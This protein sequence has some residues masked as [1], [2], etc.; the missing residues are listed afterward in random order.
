MA[1]AIKSFVMF[2]LGGAG[3]LL[4]PIL[5]AFILEAVSTLSWSHLLNYHLGTLGVIVILIV[6]FLPKGVIS[7][8]Q[9]R[10]FFSTFVK[11]KVREERISLP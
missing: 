3:T 11:K 2:L 1:I 6:I 5:G 7:F 10:F 9:E 4:G 8:I